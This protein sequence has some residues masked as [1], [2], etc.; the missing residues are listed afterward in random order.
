MRIV[1][2][3]PRN[4][5]R[6]YDMRKVIDLYEQI[7]VTVDPK[8]QADLFRQILEINMNHLWEIGITTSPPQPCV[9][10]N[11]FFNVPAKA[12]WDSN[13]RSPGNTATEQYSFK[14]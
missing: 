13:V 10:K 3:V 12:L 2:I 6:V 4:G 7:K 8:V 9:V 11:N 5:R 1:D 14:S